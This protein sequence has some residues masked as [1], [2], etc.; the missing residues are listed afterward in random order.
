MFGKRKGRLF[1]NHVN[2][3]CRYCSNSS[4]F[5]GTSVCRLRRCLDQQGSCDRFVYDPLKR[6]PFTLPPLK[7]HDPDEFKL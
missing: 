3:D 5:N 6:V 4:D 1:G 7:E 2:A